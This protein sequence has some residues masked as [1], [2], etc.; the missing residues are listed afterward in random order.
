MLSFY[1][2]ILNKTLASDIPPQDVKL[3]LRTIKT[4]ECSEIS[5]D[6]L[7]SL[8]CGWFDQY[9]TD[10]ASNL[11]G[12]LRQTICYIDYHLNS[13]EVARE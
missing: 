3:A 7:L 6:F 5:M 1:Y 13:P 12:D 9:Y 10:K 4:L 2:K 8:L 11:A